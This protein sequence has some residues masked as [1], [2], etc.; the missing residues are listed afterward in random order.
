M[1]PLK[2]VFLWHQ[3]QPYYKLEDKFILPWTRFH[4]VK[5]YFD[6]PEILHEFPKI[7]QTFNLV[8]S[9]LTQIQDYIDGSTI[10]RI[11]ELTAIHAKNLSLENKKD[12]IKLFFACNKEHM[13]DP[14]PRYKY[15]YDSSRDE[16]HAL[17]NFQDQ[18]WT[19]LQVWYNLTW[20]GP[21]SRLN[22][23]VKRMFS[24]G[25]NFS[26][27]EK[28]IVLEEHNTVLQRIVPQHKRLM[29]FNQIEIS[30]SPFYHPIVPLLIDSMSAR[31]SMKNLIMPDPIFMYPDDAKLQIDKAL[32]FHKQMFGTLPNGMWPSEG[33]ISDD[34]LQLFAEKGIQWV[35]TDEEVLENSLGKKFE[36]TEK[37]FPHKYRS[38][39][40]KEISILFR[41]HFLS[42]R[43]GFVY[44]QWNPW[45]AANDFTHHLKNIRNEIIKIHGE[46]AL[47]YAAVSIIL[48]GENCWEYYPEN[49]VP[50]LRELYGRISD[51]REFKT[52]T[53]SDAIREINPQ[54]SKQLNKI[55]AGSWINSNFSIWIGHDDDRKAWS[56]LGKAR[57]LYEN[58]KVNLNI[59]T[60]EQIEEAIMI[61]EGSDWFWWYG[62][63]HS[64]ENK[65]DFDTLFRFYIRKIYELMN[66]EVPE[67]V[68]IPISEQT[69]ISL[70]T[71]PLE[72]ISPQID[73][74]VSD[75][76]WSKAGY[77]NAQGAMSAMHQIG[78]ILKGMYFGSD[79]SNLYF[80]FDADFNDKDNFIYF[81]ILFP[82]KIQFR[83]EKNGISLNSER[84]IK[85]I[86]SF[87]NKVIEF[88]IDKSAFHE[89]YIE[90]KLKLEV[91]IKTVSNGNELTYP[92]KGT[93][94]LYF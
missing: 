93:L 27:F 49:G 94:E 40:G 48:D 18:D 22:S 91:I 43:I 88:A 56:M 68:N 28:E 3:H 34:A 29:E 30:C 71:Q 58:N 53:C 52:V 39:T 41:D 21:Y 23:T 51:E 79:N 10:D 4:G 16:N 1:I 60:K 37:F 13:I 45:D 25:E 32:D 6:L 42:D 67:I 7:K 76:E 50:F 82:I 55:Q 84:G 12:I 77:Y 5:D 70:M 20:F 81:D 78:E 86:K 62:P 46:D 38:K 9:M 57:L 92:R 64:T 72:H 61:A 66:E 26:E 8:P 75:A 31:E 47:N 80:R 2:I 24:K 85:F 73:G 54:Y 90:D 89:Y 17:A 74:S 44:S 15:L 36:P 35:A 14:Y 65:P 59:E 63:E 69:F 87:K 83:F 19:D 11:Q 33:S